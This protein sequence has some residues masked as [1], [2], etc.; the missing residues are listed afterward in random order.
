MKNLPEQLSRALA[1]RY[2]IE[3][4]LGAG[5]M[6]TVYLAHDIRH[7]RRVAIK[8]LRPE[9]A[10]V[11]GAERFLSE[12]KTTANLQH[13]HI[14]GLI[15][16][17]TAV[18][19]HESR[20]TELATLDPR[21]SS[22]VYY[23]MP[24]VDGESLRDRLEREKQLGVTEAVRI[25]TEVASALDYA[26]RH[27]VIHRDI[28]PENILL[29]DGQALV[30]DFGIALAVSRSDG[31]SRMTETG[32]SLGTPH[33]MSPEQAMG[34]REITA[35]SDVYALGAMTYEMLVGEPP[36]SGPTAQ[37]IVARV[38]T[39][40]PAPISATRK[41]VPEHVE[42]AVLTALQKLPADRFATAAG[43]ADALTGRAPM[44]NVTSRGGKSA[45]KPWH[46]W[47]GWT[48]L[49]VAAVALALIAWRRFTEPAPPEA[50]FA[51]AL[52][53]G[54]E[55]ALTMQ[56]THFAVSQDGALLVYTGGDSVYGRLWVKRRNSLV[57]TSI[58]GTEGA[59]NP[60]ISPDNRSVG[61]FTDVNG[62]TL[63]VVPLS[64]GPARTVVSA[65]LGNS[66]AA[67]G[68]DGYIYFD[69]DQ[70]GL[71]RIRPDGSDR[72][73][74]LPLDVAHHEAGIAW[75]QVLPG[76][77][78]VIMRMRRLDDVPS[79]FSIVA[80]RIGSGQR[81]TLARGVSAA[82]LAGHL[83]F[84]TADGTLDIAPFS[85]K[86]LKLT[87]PSTAVLS[88]VRI[89][90]N[91]SGVDLAAAADGTL[92]Y[93]AG[94]SAAGAQ[95]QW[96]ERNGTA[97]PVD[98][99]WSEAGEIRG[100]ALSPDG[101]K[102]AVEISRVGSTGTDIWIKLLPNGPLSRLTLDP[103]SDSR[104]VFSSD[105]R[106]V[107]F[108]SERVSPEAIFERSAD[109]AGD[110]RLLVQAKRNITEVTLS[111]DGKWLVARTSS[112]DSGS[113]DILAMQI[114]RDSTLRPII[115]TP[116]AETNP[117]L[118][119]DGRWLAYVSTATGRREVYVRPFPN[120]N[121][122]V[123]LIS[124]DGGF[125]PRWSN[126]GRE[127]FFR[128]NTGTD[129]ILVAD[130]QTAPVF[131]AGTPHPLLST[132]AA[133]GLDYI[134][135]AVSPDD[136]RFLMVGRTNPDVQPDLVRIEHFDDHLTEESAP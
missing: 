77:H 86:A 27:G 2:R 80:V 67:W 126:S 50:R 134:R 22:L 104:P 88:A 131:H 76:A 95:V 42:D 110:D 23:V 25:A 10:A 82:Y 124:T 45:R 130:V 117:A 15:D 93:L 71:Q 29:H 33:Y 90:G 39:A 68:S 16:S 34:E 12:I 28:K 87:G 98:P 70:S 63:K 11:I 61:F 51:V 17:G 91:Y 125:E 116:A 96:V 102:A 118:S 89:A 79:D 52:P 65:P 92:Y 113:D 41:R 123:W 60:F 120:V 14:L 13:P 47:I 133:V 75:P 5:G 100:L 55:L 59:Y 43:F 36:F 8:V 64:G 83:L 128:R 48:G 84:I 94:S 18:A 99:N 44:R 115:G 107:I 56:G 135:Y 127:L 106:S 129:N 132:D 73:T 121:D 74:I 26:H 109:G 53:R 72:S 85:E 62:R 122:G 69:A 35:R 9:L 20:V 19:D 58:P 78:T 3:R 21:P 24:F 101:S 40:E 38:L 49:G 108:L 4:E 81:A 37:A 66:G 103:A 119:P 7:D 136:R 57:A 31:A 105:G 46:G 1:D 112:A 97:R 32:M 30:A 6:A 54:Q 114:G 111:R